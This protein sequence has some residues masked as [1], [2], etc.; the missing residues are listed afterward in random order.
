MAHMTQTLGP[1]IFGPG[2]PVIS[3]MSLPWG[4]GAKGAFSGS[5]GKYLPVPPSTK[6]ALAGQVVEHSSIKQWT[7]LQ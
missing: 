4:I 7:F 2:V 5:G 6:V 1:I 3:F